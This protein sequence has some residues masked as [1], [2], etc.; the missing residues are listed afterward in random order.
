MCLRTV[1]LVPELAPWKVLSIHATG[2]DEHSRNVNY[3][4]MRE[5][6]ILRTVA[7]V[8]EEFGGLQA[9]ADWAGLG[10]TAVSNWLAR[11]F[12]PP[13]WHFRMSEHFAERGLLLAGSVFGQSEK[14][15]K[16]RSDE[17][18]AA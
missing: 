14:N 6:R 9:A 11:G 18:T 7:E 1:P 3:I 16:P 13:G 8:V 2:L 5:A 15:P 10:K 12:I 4:A 17:R